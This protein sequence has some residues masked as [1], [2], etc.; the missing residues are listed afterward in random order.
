M[1]HRKEKNLMTPEQEK[2]LLKSILS[3]GVKKGLMFYIFHC[4]VPSCVYAHELFFCFE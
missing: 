1:I 2:N 3:S 4:L